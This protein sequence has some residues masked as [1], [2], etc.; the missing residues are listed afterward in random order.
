M[1]LNERLKP[2][3][4]EPLWLT[5]PPAEVEAP[6]LFRAVETL[7]M[8]GVGIPVAVRLADVTEEFVKEDDALTGPAEPVALLVEP[9]EEIITLAEP[10]NELPEDEPGAV[11]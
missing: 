7:V 5:G 11:N 8:I 10:E 6:V 9:Y 4:L 3:E 1:G 2:S